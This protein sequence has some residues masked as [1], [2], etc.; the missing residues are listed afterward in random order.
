MKNAILSLCLFVAVA[1]CRDAPPPS[2][3]GVPADTS[4]ADS[5][6]AR[7]LAEF[8][9][10]LPEVQELSGGAPTLDS[11][12]KAVTTAM[13]ANDRERLTALGMNR[14]EFAWIYYP[15]NPQALPPYDLDPGTLW[16]M[17]ESQSAK[18]L[19]RAMERLNSMKLTFQKL[20]CDEKPSIEGEN[21]VFGPCIVTLTD[22]KGAVSEG[23][24][25]SQVI[26]RRGQWKVVSYANQLD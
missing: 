17:L 23:R 22:A 3:A 1:A 19:G 6:R 15:T 20:T 11:L 14:A 25:F 2:P 21:R 10:G 18:G 5:T 13:M 26:S 8:R 7:E 12:G 24:I 16:M 9:A 4:S